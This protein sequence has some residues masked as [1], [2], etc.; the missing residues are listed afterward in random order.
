MIRGRLVTWSTVN[1]AAEIYDW[2]GFQEEG[3]L[4][5]VMRRNLG[6]EMERAVSLI[7]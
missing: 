7:G 6:D 2:L 4:L 1:K 5:W 3:F